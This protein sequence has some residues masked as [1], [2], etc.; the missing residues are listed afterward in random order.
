MLLEEK[1]Q[2]KSKKILIMTI[3]INAIV[4]CRC[5]YDYS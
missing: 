3:I 4:S 5:I 2:K 1:I